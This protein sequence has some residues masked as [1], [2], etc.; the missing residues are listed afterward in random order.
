MKAVREQ[1]DLSL[2][3][4]RIENVSRAAAFKNSFS[5]YYGLESG[6]LD[7]EVLFEKL[8][9]A[10]GA[11]WFVQETDKTKDLVDPRM[12]DAHMQEAA[13]SQ[14]PLSEVDLALKLA[15]A[16]ANKEGYAEVKFWGRLTGAQTEQLSKLAGREKKYV[17]F[18]DVLPPEKRQELLESAKVTRE[19][20]TGLTGKK[21]LR[22]FLGRLENI[23]T[24]KKFPDEK[25]A[26]QFAQFLKDWKDTEPLREQIRKGREDI[27]AAVAQALQQAGKDAAALAKADAKALL[28]AVGKA[29]LRRDVPA[30]GVEIIRRQAALTREADQVVRLLD[31]WIIRERLGKQ[32]PKPR[33]D[34][35]TDEQWARSL[36]GEQILTYAS[37]LE[38][39]T[40]LRGMLDKTTGMQ[41]LGMTADRVQAAGRY[42]VKA[43][44]LSDIE[45]SVAANVG[46]V[47][48]WGFSGRTIWL[49]VVSFLVCVVG[50]ANAMLMSVTER[51]R[52]IA[53][54][55]CLGATD[56]F[57]MINFVLESC[58]QGVAGGVIGTVLGLLLGSLRGAG[59]YGWI[60]LA[61]YPVG[62]VLTAA[63]VSLV[64]GVVISALAAVYPA[65]VAARLAPMEAMRIE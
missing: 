8:S 3:V 6:E 36:D 4:E 38:G 48:T 63:G 37:D 59:M 52:E 23:D 13:A 35:R 65:W 19:V 47:A 2:D 1:A 49:L 46:D 53:T 28:E 64:A 10:R 50:I 15:E 29:G 60:A 41:P 62:E 51:F 56:G 7:Y 30:D 22:A 14:L 12:S 17:D 33:N 20:L 11:R 21:A 9:S 34:K 27:Q 40:W 61:N 32:I 45:A 42:W 43:K 39:A 18:F 44:T 5:E 25:P 54:M 26:E 31:A 55:K 57:I 58:I 24:D 16:A